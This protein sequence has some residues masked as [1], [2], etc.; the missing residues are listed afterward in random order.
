MIDTAPSYSQSLRRQLSLPDQQQP[1]DMLLSAAEHL[2]TKVDKEYKILAYDDRFV[3]PS[4][5]VSVVHK[6]K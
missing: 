6:V 5:G 2:T 3:A 1:H 4:Y